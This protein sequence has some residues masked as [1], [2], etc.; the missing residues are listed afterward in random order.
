MTAYTQDFSD[1]V[2]LEVVYQ[3]CRNETLQRYPTLKSAEQG[4]KHY[5]GATIVEYVIIKD[6]NKWYVWEKTPTNGSPCLRSTLLP[7][8]Y[9]V[10]ALW[11]IVSFNKDHG[12]CDAIETTNTARGINF[13]VEHAIVNFHAQEKKNIRGR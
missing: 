12:V 11:R 9:R 4:A 7:I 10:G 2:V 5:L 8:V 1:P 13:L 6:G 3:D